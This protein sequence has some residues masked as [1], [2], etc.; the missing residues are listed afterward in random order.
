MFAHNFAKHTGSSSKVSRNGIVALC[1]AMLVA[2]SALGEVLVYE[3]FSSS[4]Y[5]T[6]SINNKKPGS[7]SIGLDKS[8]G[9]N[10]GTGV[11]LVRN[12]GL[13]FP[14]G[15]TLGGTVHGPEAYSLALSNSNNPWNQRHRRA[16][17]CTI[18]SGWP[19]SGSLY[20]RFL[21]RVPSALLTT[22]YLMDTEYWMAGLGTA[23][24]DN[25]TTDGCY[26]KPG[27]WMGVRNDGGTLKFSSYVLKGDK[28][29]YKWHDFFVVDT[30]K[31]LDCVCMAKID[32]GT[33]GN[34]TVS[35]HAVPTADWD[36][37][38][39]WSVVMTGAKLI[40][41]DQPL[42][43]LAM[44]G[45]Y[46]T[47]NKDV[48]FD[49]FIVTTTEQEAF[50]RVKAGAP[51]LGDVSVERTGVGTFSLSA[52]E[53]LVTADILSIATDGTTAVTN[54][55]QAG[56][57]AG[58]TASGTISGLAEADKTYEISAF[59]TNSVGTYKKV[60][61]TVYTGEL[62][63]GA[64]VDA[65]EG[66]LTAGTVAV[67]RA[68]ADPFPLVVNYTISSAAGAQDVTWEV[69]EAVEIPAGS[70]TGY[71]L[72]K[73][74]PDTGVGTNITVT[75]A[76]AAGNYEI[77]A[78]PDNS[79]DLKILNSD[80]ITGYEIVTFTN[81]FD[82]PL[83]ANGYMRSPHPDVPS[84]GF[85]NLTARIIR[86]EDP[87]NAPAGLREYNVSHVQNDWVTFSNTDAGF[88]S[89]WMLY[90]SFTKVGTE[91]TTVG[92]V[93]YAAETLSGQGK[94]YGV[95]AYAGSWYVPTAG[96]YSFRMH[97]SYS[98]LF[99]L[100]GQLL[101]RQLGSTAVVKKDV[102]L[103]AGWHNFYAALIADGSGNIGPASGESCGLAFS[104]TNGD[105]PDTAFATA[106][107]Y[108]LSTA[109]NAV[110][111]PSM[112]AEGGEVVIDC[113]NVLGDL[114]IAGQ[115][116]TVNHRFKFVNLP[117]GRTL[118]FGRP[119]SCP[120]GT[121][122]YQDFGA[123]AYVD[124]TRVVIPSGVN[125]RFEGG[126]VVDKNWSTTGLGAYT[127]G[128]FVV[129]A[130]DVP[131]FFGT[132]TD[133]F[134]YPAGIRYLQVGSTEVLGN[135]ATVYVPDNASFGYGCT[136]F[137]L[138][139]NNSG[140]KGL[141]VTRNYNTKLN[142]MNNVVLGSNAS[143]NGTLTQGGG[144][145]KL[146][147]TVT[148]PQGS[149]VTTG[150]CR[151]L[152]VCGSANVKD[153]SAGQ[154]G[155]RVELRPPANSEPSSITG[156]MTLSSEA[157]SKGASGW[158]CHGA[159]FFYSPEVPGVQPLSVG[160]VS[161][162]DA[163]YYPENFTT[164]TN[165]NVV[166]IAKSTVRQ[167]ATLSTC[168]NNTI[169]VSTM[170]GKGVHLR[171][172]FPSSSGQDAIDEDLEKG[173]GPANFVFDKINGA[174]GSNPMKIFV[175]SNVNITVTNV[176]KAAAFHYEVM[177]NGVNAAVLDVVTNCAAGSTITATDVAMLPARIKGFTGDITL[178]DNTAGRTYPVVFNFD[179]KGGIPIGG[180]DGSGNLVAAPT[181]G[182][183]ELTFAGDHPKTG[184]WGILKFDSVPAG[185]L[186]E[187]TISPESAVYKGYVVTVTKTATGFELHAGKGLMLIVR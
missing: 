141:P 186:D 148:G 159:M 3:G 18:T 181:S 59:A 144:Y 36:G 150:W 140:K 151:R 9:W 45:Q 91:A 84:N 109:F 105:T 176:A 27:I 66:T 121:S 117:A 20:F 160:T 58:S 77:K 178:T 21:M 83:V 129:L 103:A 167:G 132:L 39:D 116:G 74:L 107:G 61:G 177:S 46:P 33:G 79:K 29:E 96:T 11:F 184:N 122:G 40:S 52:E 76:L 19:S 32:I 118:E 12:Y 142:F 65:N 10:S 106:G 31:Q 119:I 94:K 112:W 125:I 171:A 97:M 5:A 30:S 149:L 123:F 163:G 90:T 55:A 135:T 17:H 38:F 98:G 72:V 56:V 157:A 25:P 166:T 80:T 22:G 136:P 110:L 126:M 78:S 42:S 179:E 87:E 143:L 182:T 8:S 146:Y 7:K 173:A 24:I 53:M 185:M 164:K 2:A 158:N 49:E 62:T 108:K 134:H 15:W 1:A 70:T 180:C 114:R 133:E 120:P 170:T 174:D 82:N 75:V 168:S 131:N 99:S 37:G 102:E 139:V 147:G 86:F 152:T 69:P 169:N 68:N 156:T 115:L 71:L 104:A 95:R 124:W 88:P 23:K 63:L 111:V 175:S 73:P 47:S 100:D 48:T 183:I 14:E 137:A 130:T 60:A 64:T 128:K 138:S 101:L 89:D 26:T 113:A 92:T 161:A 165:N 57:A 85:S 4:D 81:A 41:V 13:E 93:R 28:S 50:L 16:Q 187:W 153:V 154:R 34:D 155:C 6:G 35:L 43:A 67:T 145:D 127:L 44:I 162:N 172:A 54:L 51:F